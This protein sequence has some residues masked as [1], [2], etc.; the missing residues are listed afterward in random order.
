MS[1]NY[2]QYYQ[3]GK[4]QQL[5]LEITVDEPNNALLELR[6]MAA[7]NMNDYKVALNDFKT[8]Y[9]RGSKPSHCYHLGLCYMNMNNFIVAIDWFDK[10]KTK[11][12]FKLASTINQSYCYFQIGANEQAIENL[13]SLLKINKDIKQAHYLLIDYFKKTKQI[14]ALE[15]QLNDS[16]ELCSN[17]YEWQKNLCYLQ[18]FQNKHDALHSYVKRAKLE[19]REI[20]NILA[21]SYVKCSEFRKAASIYLSI[22]E[23]GNADAMQWYNLAAAYSHLTSDVDLQNALEA[24]KNCLSLDEK[25]DQAYYCNAV[26][27]EKLSKIEKATH[28]IKK[29]I[30][31]TPNNLAYQYKL[32]EL[33][34]LQNKKPESLKLIKKIIQY[35]P[36]Y[37]L[38]Q[39]LKGIIELQLNQAEKSEETLQ[40]AIKVDNTDQR[41][42][43]YYTIAKLAQNKQQEVEEFMA[44]GHFVKEFKFDPKPD[45]K[46]LNA[47]NRDLEKDIK[48][49]SL[50]RKEPNGLAARNGYL[51]DNIYKDETQ[52]IVL[53][54][55][56]LEKK[57]QQYIQELPNDMAHHM[58]R[59]KTSEY[60]INSWAT[61]VQGDGFIDKHIHE[62]SWLSGAYYCTVPK[63]TTA[64][65]DHEGYFEYG[66]IPNDITI[67]INKKRGYIKPV[68]GKLVI[69]P[70]YLYHQTIPHQ[71]SEDR[72]SIAFDLTPLAWIK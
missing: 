20:K 24:S 62:E 65:R 32:A 61:W 31:L 8:L 14:K 28:E 15:K 63:I 71:T 56:L 51:T 49:H 30:A 25:F 50:L 72:I 66:C 9:K 48:N 70:S 39:R 69:F 10:S 35:N 3:E 64:T 68:E 17:E 43:A 21:K 5:L 29:A 59:H 18:L 45:Y 19:S 38:A 11:E 46:G 23:Q 55:K 7:I 27:Y 2:Q 53:F 13:K 1:L 33:L 16:S 54:R 6:A 22:I 57:I 34:N 41:S 26:V 44:L 60:K 36:K 47:F 40:K 58:L 67:D 4:F 12:Q 52:S 37:N 42:L